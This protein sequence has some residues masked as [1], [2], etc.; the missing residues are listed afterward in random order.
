MGKQHHHS[1]LEAGERRMVLAI[2]INPDP[3]LYRTII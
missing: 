1:D 3:V 2:A